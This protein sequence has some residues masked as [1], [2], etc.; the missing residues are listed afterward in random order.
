MYLNIEN[1]TN[2]CFQNI[3]LNEPFKQAPSKETIHI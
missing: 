1:S 3:L 2:I